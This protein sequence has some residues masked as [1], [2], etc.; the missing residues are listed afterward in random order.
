VRRVYY[1]EGYGDDMADEMAREADMQLVHL[2][3]EEAGL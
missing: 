1:A 2:T 3:G